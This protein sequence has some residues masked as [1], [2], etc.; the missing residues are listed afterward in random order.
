MTNINVVNAGTFIPNQLSKINIF[1]LYGRVKFKLMTPV[2]NLLYIVQGLF[3]LN[4]NNSIIP[5]FFIR[6]AS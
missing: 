3:T 6:N 2:T 4:S 1:K 5:H